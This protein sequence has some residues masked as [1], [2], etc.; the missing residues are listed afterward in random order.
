MTKG[1]F[2]AVVVREESWDVDRRLRELGLNRAGLNSAIR[3]AVA[4]VA[5][6][7]DNSPPTARGLMAW[8]AGVVRLR[9]EFG[10]HGWVRDDTANFSTIINHRQL[11]K[12]AVA[13]TDDATGNVRVFPTN[14][15]KKGE[16][17]KQAAFLNQLRLPF[18]GWS[19]EPDEAKIPGF[20]TWYLCIYVN[21][22]TVRAE[23]SLPTRIENGFF[24]DWSER[25]ILVANDDGWRRTASPDVDEGDGPE[26]Q[27]I[28]S[29]K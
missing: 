3:A 16:L 24:A 20:A 8:F 9:E 29:R 13:N 14:R 5:G 18:D 25:I 19:A 1:A 28:V 10:M 27:V 2:V 21:E 23:L 7:T 15:S 17:G 11:A 26:F 22:E 6:C 4:A 12:I